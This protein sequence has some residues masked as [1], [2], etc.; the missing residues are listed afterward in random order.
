MEQHDKLHG[1]ALRYLSIR[2][3]TNFEMM[4]YLTRKGFESA[5]VEAELE[6]LAEAGLLDDRQF[7]ES[8]VANRQ[9]LRPRSRRQLEQELMAKRVPSAV[10]TEV[11]DG[12]A[13]DSLALEAVIQKKRRLPQYGD[14]RR[15]VEYLQRQGFRYDQIKKALG[16]L[17]DVGS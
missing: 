2:S 4:D 13:D 15:L 9:M 6:R 11:L 12:L 16:R 3:R 8:W 1:I 5:V 7:A 17:D 10:I 14:D